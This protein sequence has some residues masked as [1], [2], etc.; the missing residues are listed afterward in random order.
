MKKDQIELLERLQFEVEQE[1]LTY[2]SH[3]LGFGQLR[4]MII[5]CIQDIE[6][7]VPVKKWIPVNTLAEYDEAKAN[8]IP[9]AF[10][11]GGGVISRNQPGIFTNE[12]KDHIKA[13][14]V[15]VLKNVN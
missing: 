12:I 11:I 9:V 5:S 1:M 2:G 3:S 6:K 15:L 14:I 10:L 13:G 4:S 8:K 7:D